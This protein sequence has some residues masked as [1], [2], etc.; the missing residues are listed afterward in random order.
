[1]KIISDNLQTWADTVFE[2]ITAD[3]GQHEWF[4]P[5]SNEHQIFEQAWMKFVN[6]NL[7]YFAFP[8]I[9][10]QVKE[11][12]EFNPA[13]PK[14]LELCRYARVLSPVHAKSPFGRMCVWNLPPGKQLLPHRDNYMY[15]RFITRNI[16]IVSDNTDNSMIIK[17]E[18]QEAPA[19]KG[20]L[21]QFHPDVELHTFHNTGD[22]HFY[23]LG[24]DF[25][26]ERKLFALQSL[27][28]HKK[29]AEDPDRMTTF[30]GLGKLSKYISKH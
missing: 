4:W 20:S 17:I 27:V 28:D 5:K 9:I 1:M 18:N 6:R 25:W 29:L 14:T 30:G 10:A 16:F 2:E 7:N 11:G 15:H 23:F 22:K 8:S 26:D 3:E 21:W 19:Q 13:L 24:F 12:N